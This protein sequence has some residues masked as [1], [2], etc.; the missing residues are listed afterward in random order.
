[1]ICKADLQQNQVTHMPRNDSE[2]DDRERGGGETVGSGH[3]RT[4][5]K[6]PSTRKW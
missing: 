6:G 5:G 1:M 3:L 2:R 4:K